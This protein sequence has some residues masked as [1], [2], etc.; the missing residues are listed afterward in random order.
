MD[1]SDARYPTVQQLTAYW[2]SHPN[3]SDT[4]EGICGWWFENGSLA[5]TDVASALGWLV[6]SGV[7]AVHTAV[8]GRI[9]YRLAD[10]A[11]SRLR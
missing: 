6:E 8:D 5:S 1:A 2:L 3:A 11:R 9:R 7:V 4:L 10:D